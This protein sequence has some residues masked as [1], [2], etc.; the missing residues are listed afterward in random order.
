MGAAF[1]KPYDF[2]LKQSFNAVGKNVFIGA[3]CEFYG[4]QNISIGNHCSIGARTI[5]MTTRARIYVGDYVMFGPDVF[6][7][8]GDHRIDIK[9]KPMALVTDQE[10]RRIMT[11]IY[12]L[13]VTIGLAP[14]RSF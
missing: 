12:I 13:R 11:G 1:R 10:K 9:G 8:S 14:D 5:F 7:V 3:K 4:I 2:V 6:V